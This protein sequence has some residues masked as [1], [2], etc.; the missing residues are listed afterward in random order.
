[1]RVLRQC[2]VPQAKVMFFTIQRENIRPSN[3]EVNKA[4]IMLKLPDVYSQ[5]INH[6]VYLSLTNTK[7]SVHLHAL[8]CP[9]LRTFTLRSDQLVICG[10]YF[11][12]RENNT[13][14][15]KQHFKAHM[16]K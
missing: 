3:K 7:S 2:K 9:A 12:S 1:M 10:Q 16:N 15:Q 13:R 14:H 8:Y 5:A 6:Y 4:V 11:G